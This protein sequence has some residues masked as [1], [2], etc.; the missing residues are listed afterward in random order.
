VGVSHG[1]SEVVVERCTLERN[2]FRTKGKGILVFE[3]ASAELIGNTVR[4]NRDG[5][6]ISGRARASLIGNTIVDNYD[7]GLGVTGAE[8]SG[9]DNVIA[10]NGRDGPDGKPGPNADGLRVTL[11]SK[12]SLL[13]TEVM[14][15]GDTGVVALG[16]S[17]VK[18]QGGRVSGHKGL[19]VNAREH[20][21]VELREVFFENNGQGEFRIDGEAKLVRTGGK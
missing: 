10:R 14:D 17:T 15:N 20:A 21:V 3:Y 4:R 11:D 6:T 16:S 18:L 5:V 2:G 7:K 8:A 1:A 19:G 13:N 9:R 12:V